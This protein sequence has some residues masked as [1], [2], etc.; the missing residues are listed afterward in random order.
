MTRCPPEILGASAEQRLDYYKHTVKVD[1]P[2]MSDTVDALDQKANDALDR[3]LILLVGGT[4]VGKSTAMLKLVD[5]R[6]A[7]RKNEIRLRPEIAPAIFVEAEA[8]DKG[9]FEFG[10]FYREGLV[11]LGSPLVDQTLPMVNRRAREHILLTLGIENYRQRRLDPYALKLRFRSEI[12]S[13]ETELVAL[14]EAIN[15]FK[16]GRAKSEKDRLLLL[17]DQADKLK[18]LIN[19]TPAALILSGAYDFYELTLCS[20]QNARR[21]VIVHMEPYDS[22]TDGLKGFCTALVGLVE[23]LPVRHNLDVGA[24]A[25][26]MYL[27]CLGCVGIAKEILSQALL[28]SINAGKPLNFEHVQKSYY[29]AS[30]LTVMREE[31][32]AGVKAVREITSLASLAFHAG[33]A[34]A[35]GNQKG[36]RLAMAP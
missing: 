15:V 28:L 31:M 5:R 7:R 8:P 34:A 27:Q 19:K 4:G 26:E 12:V 11:Q 22:T 9:P 17:K 30:Q 2:I 6:N 21:S 32:A 1:H 10:T 35:K 33:N 18:T 16:T 14:D 13:R 36:K 25:T 3:R 23:H 24:M 20:G 29:S